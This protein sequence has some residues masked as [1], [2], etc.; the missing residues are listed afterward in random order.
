MDRREG[1]VGEPG[2]WK[3][4]DSVGRKRSYCGSRV[5]LVSLSKAANLTAVI[6]VKEQTLQEKTD[7]ILQK[8]QEIFQLKK[9]EESAHRAF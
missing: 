1:L 8:E 4:G 5:M 9:G 3:G 7:V 6:D 2:W